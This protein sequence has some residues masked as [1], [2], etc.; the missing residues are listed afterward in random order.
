[1]GHVVRTFPFHAQRVLLQDDVDNAFAKGRVIHLRYSQEELVGDVLITPFAAGHMLGGAI[2]KLVKETVRA[3][4][5]RDPRCSWLMLT[6]YATT[7]R[8]HIRR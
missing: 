2:W 8:D 1:M 7:G 6:E 3:V 5:E 4:N